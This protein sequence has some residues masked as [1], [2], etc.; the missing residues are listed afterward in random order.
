MSLQPVALQGCNYYPVS[1]VDGHEHDSFNQ[2]RAFVCLGQSP[3]SSLPRLVH[4][5]QVQRV[6][7]LPS[8]ILTLRTLDPEP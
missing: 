7:N 5:G 1:R 3:A 8:K 2:T 4:Q 6:P